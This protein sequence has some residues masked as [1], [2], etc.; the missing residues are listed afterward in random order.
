MTLSAAL[1][2]A[3]AMVIFVASPG[4]GIF[5]VVGETMARGARSATAMTIAPLR[6]FSRLVLFAVT[7]R[8]LF[9][10]VS[11]TTA[12]AMSDP[13]VGAE[14][15]LHRLMDTWLILLLRLLVGVFAVGI[16]SWMVLSCV[17]L[18]ATQSATGILYF[19]S[20]F[21]YVGELAGFHLLAT[22]DWPI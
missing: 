19:S 2:Y 9:A 8:A 12:W 11:V 7:A 15:A 22:C 17:R 1:L 14:P 6:H 16:F 4:P 20:V 5:A 21:A 10:V 18:R 13:A 3:F